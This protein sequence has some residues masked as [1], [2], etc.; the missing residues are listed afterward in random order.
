MHTYVASKCDI[1]DTVE[2]NNE[3]IATVKNM[4][5]LNPKINI[6]G[7]NIYTHETDKTYDLIIFDLWWHHDGPE[8]LSQKHNLIQKYMNNLNEGGYLYFPI[9]PITLYKKQNA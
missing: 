1:I 7:G 3:L 8:Y 2:I 4:G 6:M 5:Y 9:D